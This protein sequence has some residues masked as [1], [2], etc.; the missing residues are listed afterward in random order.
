MILGLINDLHL[1]LFLEDGYAER[2]SSAVRKHAWPKMQ[3][4]K[5]KTIQ[6]KHLKVL[7]RKSREDPNTWWRNCGIPPASAHTKSQSLEAD[8]IYLM[9]A[10][11]MFPWSKA[12]EHTVRMKADRK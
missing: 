9:M 6:D 2:G 1:Y 8:L 10:M 11:K 12:K 7:G 3:S 5:P 4:S